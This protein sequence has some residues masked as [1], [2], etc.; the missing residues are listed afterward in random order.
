M[1]QENLGYSFLISEF[2]KTN[3]YYN[4]MSPFE[5]QMW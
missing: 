5:N 1:E 2:H 4:L 3:P